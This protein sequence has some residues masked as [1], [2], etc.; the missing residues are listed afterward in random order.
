V[1][2]QDAQGYGVPAVVSGWVRRRRLHHWLEN[3]PVRYKAFEA[4]ASLLGMDT[5]YDSWSQ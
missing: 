1:A 5:L 2:L 4:V 3:H